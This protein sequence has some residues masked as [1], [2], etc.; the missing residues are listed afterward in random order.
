MTFVAE[1]S[2]SVSSAPAPLPPPA[3]PAPETVTTERPSGPDANE[4]EQRRR[5]FDDEPSPYQRPP[6]FREGGPRADALPHRGGLVLTFG[7]LSVALTMFCGLLSPIWGFG[8][9]IPAWVMGHGDLKKMKSGM[10][11]TSGEAI[12]R[13]G[14]ILGIVGTGLAA[15]IIL[16][17]VAFILLM[18]IMHD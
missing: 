14:W 15:V 3:P 9:G 1:D 16:I 11:D 13:A 4:P 7:I 17:F 6:R 12:T 10:M 8:F 18:A 2:A 5:D